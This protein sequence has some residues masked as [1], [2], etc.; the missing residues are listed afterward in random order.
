LN[1]RPLRPEACPGEGLRP[2]AD[3]AAGQDHTT[4][5]GDLRRWDPSAGWTRDAALRDR[6]GLDVGG[7]A[8][9]TSRVS[10]PEA[11]H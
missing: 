5:G 4:N 1:S 2:F 3:T 8:R 11:R 9:W 10:Q 7:L 6:P